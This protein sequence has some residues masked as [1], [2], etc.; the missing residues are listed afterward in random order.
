MAANF[1]KVAGV[2]SIYVNLP[3]TLEK[4]LT[5]WLQKSQWSISSDFR[6]PAGSVPATLENML[7]KLASD[8]RKVSSQLA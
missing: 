5:N 4:V 6:K 7:A 2:V 8:F 1:S 3:A